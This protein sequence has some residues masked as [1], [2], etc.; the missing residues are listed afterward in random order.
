VYPSWFDVK[1]CGQSGYDLQPGRNVTRGEFTLGFSG[2]LIGV[3]GHMHDYGQELM[4]EDATRHQEVAAMHAQL[5]AQGRIISIPIVRFT[6]S[7]GFP[8]AKGDVVKVTAVYNN[9]TGKFLPDSAM[10]IVVG[11]FLPDQESAF[12]ALRRPKAGSRE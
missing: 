4:L 10:G 8:L 3:G 9:P 2:K 5:D 1:E 11:Y 6:E 12:A 7:G